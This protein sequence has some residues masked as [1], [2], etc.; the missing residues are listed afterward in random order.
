MI[1]RWNSSRNH[2][3][4]ILIIKCSQGLTFQGSPSTFKIPQQI[5]KKQSWGPFD[6]FKG[7]PSTTKARSEN[8]TK[9]S[10]NK[11]N[12]HHPPKKE[13]PFFCS[14][15]LQGSSYYQAKQGTITG[16]NPENHPAFALLDPQK[17]CSLVVS[18]HPN[19]FEK[20]ARSSNWSIFPQ[21][22]GWTSKNI[23]VATT[24]RE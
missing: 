5:D 8:S 2:Q 23:R 6:F 18:T 24:T 19:P 11:T 21:A 12:L 9:L 4:A 1:A 16:D 13:N 22:S 20:D 14:F 10:L 17:N 15:V 7:P 3:G